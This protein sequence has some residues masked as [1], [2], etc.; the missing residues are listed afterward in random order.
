MNCDINSVIHK[1]GEIIAKYPEISDK[2]IQKIA[3]EVRTAVIQGNYSYTDAQKIQIQNAFRDNIKTLCDF[4]GYAEPQNIQLSFDKPEKKSESYI[5]EDNTTSILEK[6][7]EQKLQFNRNFLE[8]FESSPETYT[9]ITH[10]INKLMC[11]A[12]L[13]N[14]LSG[15]TINQENLSLSI[16]ISQDDLLRSIVDYLN[17]DCPSKNSYTE[18]QKK[19][20]ED[21]KDTNMFD[22][23]DNYTGVVGKLKEGFI[24]ELSP[25]SG[26]NLVKLQQNANNGDAAA[27]ARIQAI[28]NYA[29]LTN[30]PKLVKSTFGDA[31]Y[32]ND[33]LPKYNYYK[34]SV[35]DKGTSV[36]K[37]WRSSD[38]IWL[39]QEINRVVQ[40]IITS[41]DIYDM[42]S[43]ISSSENQMQFNIFYQTISKIKNFANSGN[44]WD[45]EKFKNAIQTLKDSGSL[46]EYE[47]NFLNKFMNKGDA[48]FGKLVSIANLNPQMYFKLIFELLGNQTCFK[49]IMAGN[50]K[51]FNKL[52][53]SYIYSTY[54]NF[55]AS[56]SSLYQASKDNINYYSF[57]TQVMETIN[58]IN[59]N[60]FYKNDQG[61]VD[62]RELTSSQLDTINRK[63]SNSIN[64]RNF[65]ELIDFKQ[66]FQKPYDIKYITSKGTSIEWPYS[67]S[68]KINDPDGTV[69]EIYVGKNN[70]N[71]QDTVAKNELIYS[72]KTYKKEGN[73]IVIDKEAKTQNFAVNW[74]NI[75]KFAPFIKDVLG[76]D[77]SVQSTIDGLKMATG[78]AQQQSELPKYLFKLAS[79]ALFRLSINN[80][81]Q[82]DKKPFLSKELGRQGTLNRLALIY[83]EKINTEANVIY[84][85]INDSWINIISNSESDKDTME[86]ISTYFAFNQGLLSSSV[87]KDGNGNALSKESLSSLDAS[88]RT[89]WVTLNNAEDSASRGFSILRPGVLQTV[90]NMREF[91]DAYGQQKDF[92]QFTP[93]EM[94]NGLFLYNFLNT[95]TETGDE[96]K[97]NIIRIL[98]AV[99][100]DKPRTDGLNINLNQDSGLGG[101]NGQIV[102]FKQAFRDPN[103]RL[104]SAKIMK[105]ELGTFYNESIKNIEH[106]YST[107]V[108]DLLSTHPELGDL[109]IE[110][111]QTFFDAINKIAASKNMNPLDYLNSLIIEYNNKNRNN[112]ITFTDQIHYIEGKN[113][114][115]VNQ[116]LIALR[117]RFNNTDRIQSYMLESEAQL[118]S[119][120][121][122]DNTKIKTINQIGKSILPNVEDEWKDP[123]GYLILGKITYNGVEYNISSRTDLQKFMR[124]NMSGFNVEDFYD[125]DK[126]RNNFGSRLQIKL[127]PYIAKYN[128]INYLFGQEWINST[129]GMHAT[130]PSKAKFE[131]INDL[132]KR[133]Q[134]ELVDSIP[135]GKLTSVDK[136]GKI[137][138]IKSLEKQDIINYL[139]GKVNDPN[140]GIRLRSIQSSDDAKLFIYYYD[141]RILETIGNVNYTDAANYAFNQL[142]LSKKSFLIEDE[143]S[144]WNAQVKRNV[145]F[146]ATM[147]LF[148]LGQIDGISE[149]SNIAIIEEDFDTLSNIL[150]QIDSSVSPFDGATFV[151]PFT[152]RLENNS[153]NGSKVGINKKIFI[154][155][156]NAQNGTGGIIKTAGFGLTNARIVRSEYFKTMMRNMTDRVWLNEDG[157]PAIINLL[158]VDY[159]G[160]EIEK[161]PQATYKGAD[162]NY[163]NVEITKSLGNNQYEI[164]SIQVDENNIP[165]SG[166]SDTSTVTINS[167]YTLWKA[168]GGEFSKQFNG[169]EFELSED[170]INITTDLI[171]RIGYPKDKYKSI[172]EWQS[173]LVRDHSLE[174]EVYTQDAIYQPMKQGDIH[175]MPVMSSVKQGAGNINR[176]STYYRDEDYDKGIYGDPTHINFMKVKMLQS[177]I[178]LDKEHGAD[179]EEVSLMTQVISACAARGFTR[180][181]AQRLYDGMS[182]LVE[183]NIKD[184]IDALHEYIDAPD[185]NPDKFHELILRTVLDSIAHQKSDPSSLIQQV[186][187][188]IVGKL[189]EGK[190]L[191]YKEMSGKIPYSDDGIIKQINSILS[192]ALTK[193]D[194]KLKLPGVLSV[195]CPSYNIMKLYGNRFLD[196]YNGKE[197]IL[198]RQKED[199]DTHPLFVYSARNSIVNKL[200][201]VNDLIEQAENDTNIILF[202]GKDIGPDEFKT[203]STANKKLLLAN[204]EAQLTLS[205]LVTLYISGLGKDNKINLDSFKAE[206]GIQNLKAEGKSY[207][208]SKNSTLTVDGLIERII[209]DLSAKN[210]LNIQEYDSQTIKNL[211][212]DILRNYNKDSLNEVFDQLLDTGNDEELDNLNKKKQEY[213]EQLNATKENGV[214]ELYR[215]DQGRWYKITRPN[216]AVE[217]VFIDT[218]YYD[219]DGKRGRASIIEEAKAGKIIS[220]VE[221]ITKGRNLSSYDIEFEDTQGIKYGL[222]DLTPAKVLFKLNYFGTDKVGFLE[223]ASKQFSTLLL[224]PDI[225]KLSE[226]D[227]QIYQLLSEIEKES[228]DGRFNSDIV[229]DRID[230]TITN[231]EVLNFINIQARR[232]LQ[233]NLSAIKSNGSI[234]I[235][236]N[237]VT[238][239]G[240][241]SERAAEVILPKTAKA[242]FGLSNNDSLYSILS[243]N[244][245][246]A[247]KLLKHLKDTINVEHDIALRNKKGDHE[248]I[249]SKDSFDPTGYTEEDIYSSPKDKNGII[250]RLDSDGKKIY[251]ISSPNDK[252]YSKYDI[253]TGTKFEVIVTD[254]IPFYIKNHHYDLITINKNLDQEKLNNLANI[255]YEAGYKNSDNYNEAVET[256][257]KD[258]EESVDDKKQELTPEA[259]LQLFKERNELLQSN[260]L[261]LNDFSKGNPLLRFLMNYGNKQRV[262]FIK[263]LDTVA[264]RVPAQSMQSF[265]PMK[266]V[267]FDNQDKNTAYVSTSQIWLQGSDYD[268]DAVTITNFALN[269]NGIYQTWSPLAN[270]TKA[271]LLHASDK[272][273]LPTGKQINLSNIET[274]FSDISAEEFDLGDIDEL[275]GY[276][277]AKNKFFL[278]NNTNE[279]ILLLGQLIHYINVNTSDDES[280]YNIFY[281]GKDNNKQ[282]LQFLLEKINAHNKYLNTL[283][284]KTRENAIINFMTTNMFDIASN[285]VNLIEASTPIDRA[286]KPLKTVANNQTALKQEQKQA[287]IGNFMITLHSIRENQVGKSG[288]GICAVGL[289]SFFAYTQVANNIIAHGN[290]D[291]KKQATFNIV[292]N[293]K[294]Y[295]TLANAFT[296]GY[297]TNLS[298][299]E[300][301]QKSNIIRD[302]N[303]AEKLQA[304][305][306]LLANTNQDVD[307]AVTLSA[308]LSLATDNAKE[309]ALAKL[310]AGTD[311]LG[312]YIFGISIGMPF[313]EISNILTNPKIIKLGQLAISNIF[314]DNDNALNLDRV[315]QYI[316]EGPIID[317]IGYLENFYKQITD[318]SQAYL[319]YKQKRLQANKDKPQHEDYFADQLKAGLALGKISIEDLESVRRKLLQEDP[320]AD[321][322]HYTKLQ[323]LQ[324]C[325]DYIFNTEGM[326]DR[327]NNLNPVVKDFITLHRG[328]NELRV[329]GQVLHINQGLYTSEFEDLNYLKQIQ[330]LIADRYID[331]DEFKQQRNASKKNK[332]TKEQVYKQLKIDVHKFLYDDEYKEKIIKLYDNYKIAFNIPLL[333]ANSSQYFSY[334]K[335]AD[336]LDQQM[337]LISAKHRG[338]KK[339]QPTNTSSKA[340]ETL[341]NKRINILQNHYMIDKFLLSSRQTFILP[342]GDFL[343]G[344]SANVSNRGAYTE[345]Q[346]MKVEENTQV[347]LG[348][349]QGNATF[350]HW[351]ENTV[352]PALQKDPKYKDNEFI[353]SLI[354]TIMIDNPTYNKSIVYSANANMLPRSEEETIA[355]KKLQQEFLKLFPR[356]DSD[357]GYYVDKAGN[358]M[359]IRDLLFMYQ[360]IVMHNSPGE[361]KLK[362]IFSQSFDDGVIKDFYSFVSDFDV[363]DEIV[364][365][366][367]TLGKYTTLKE[368]PRSTYGGE[369]YYSLN[370]DFNMYRYYVDFQSAQDYGDYGEGTSIIKNKLGNPMSHSKLNFDN[371]HVYFDYSGNDIET[372]INL[373]DPITI[374]STTIP[375]GACRIKIHT[376]GVIPSII[377]IS[378]Q[379]KYQE[380]IEFEESQDSG[381]RNRT[382]KNAS[383]DATIALAVDFNNTGEILT[384][385]SVTDQGKKYIDVNVNDSLEVTQELVNRIVD[386]LNE[387]GAKTLNIAGNGIYTMKGKYTQ[388]QID[389]FTYDLLNN[390]INS[391][392]LENTIDSIRSGGQTGFD[393]AGIKAALRLGIHA[394]VLAP[395][396]WKFRNI[397]GTDISD[398]EDFKSRFIQGDSLYSVTW[399][400]SSDNGFEVSTS[401]GKNKPGDS[402]FS[403]KKAVFKSGTIIQ[404]EDV[405]GETIETVYQSLIKQGKLTRGDD[406]KTGV[407][408][409]LMFHDK[410]MYKQTMSKE[411]REDF[412][413]EVGYLPLWKEWA[414]QNPDLIEELRVES[415]GKVLT[416]Q[417]ATKTR[418]SQA[419]ALADILNSDQTTKTKVGPTVNINFNTKTV[420]ISDGDHE[421]KIELNPKD[422]IYLTFMNTKGDTKPKINVNKLFSQ[423]DNII[424]KC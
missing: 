57:L 77:L 271:S 269:R 373:S 194:I 178:Q 229:K 112:P 245:F 169:E 137:S 228:I 52:D 424:N 416:D 419:R 384:K 83:G 35:A 79:R 166:K 348:T 285:P 302:G 193:D 65:K 81:I 15:I 294:A 396:G 298:L 191:T 314:I 51:V 398:E 411:E 295:T 240:I 420:T 3:D 82:S 110:Y 103:W 353:K 375:A 60:Q 61:N 281:S 389:E 325:E 152:V 90:T 382:I 213:E 93:A 185:G 304:A 360:L 95:F 215:I 224:K 63:I 20:L 422:M 260:T 23:Y 288:V 280:T 159:K 31:I 28:I 316:K 401:A 406:H 7:V 106:S 170:S 278:K 410:D 218:P 17:Y 400:T 14:K 39:D 42:G 266:I 390:V 47:T 372:T 268:I 86:I 165:V 227:K 127:N 319:Q 21:I 174:G 386:E 89:Q 168:L 5:T 290:L 297:T 327:G 121:M 346:L 181:Y 359:A 226:R 44:A 146:S 332:I 188:Q 301:K 207:L 92:M 150:G 418:V 120:L 276:N 179:A 387:S 311:M 219:I 48:S 196:E 74:N 134:I 101:V 326:S 251:P 238:V 423:I 114:L 175:Y 145:S 340:K 102:T 76:I 158:G 249:I 122:K 46:S 6:P 55:F 275:V 119:Y 318:S 331:S 385:K 403:A 177:G 339:Y 299:E 183:T 136:N 40:S 317:R 138:I 200:K 334:L 222:Y 126:I 347:R 64:N 53:K 394:T 195:L 69:Y 160:Q 9:K 283:D 370:G 133:G 330:N 414:R 250:W 364:L 287:R 50:E 392:R 336:L 78:N 369:T 211:V 190:E 107:L 70:S 18:S 212:V 405:G 365:D 220:I 180:E 203:L 139:S 293:G 43:S 252:V 397:N 408:R 104:N 305:K 94:F 96:L 85:P 109:K 204:H 117:E 279:K 67:I 366:P 247:R 345:P 182:S 135:S 255:V 333:I 125:S 37:T 256:Q 368:N 232:E 13:Y 124:A 328:A 198:K 272:L 404:G 16:A 11:N 56:E 273:D 383:A 274:R 129:V 98:G 244:N 100:S 300:V 344:T 376:N 26:S 323:I 231:D 291:Q 225:N 24:S 205:G 356:A 254:N 243:D 361:Y 315:E 172:Q 209:T 415:D 241:I 270:I 264:A 237:R 262:S 246:F 214:N 113:G 49:Y 258:I 162:G 381:Y 343:Y 208:V 130:H 234:N 367:Y 233:E 306:D 202:N 303:D 236:G 163:Y 307:A 230:S 157:T 362:T 342:K 12:F 111:D 267:G 320:E 210:E 322:N 282:K 75:S 350:K 391:P 286:T 156:Y 184:S 399:A 296:P 371:D 335:L 248:Y 59:Y 216:G 144:R 277:K 38:Q 143:A 186:T 141:K 378:T 131:Y 206:T 27:K 357:F 84:N 25:L 374:G 155:Y 324:N 289:K 153:L 97:S 201:E 80:Y 1:V 263:V 239:A 105:Q 29:M 62:V 221:D 351:M 363:N 189:K 147:H 393:E 73:A 4:F 91:V 223:E 115:Q 313:T 352:I 312:I 292:I 108:L 140:L 308:L 154:H 118:F 32:V 310:N 71:V 161:L 358:K 309:L 217:S 68:F 187:K 149:D 128:H 87:T 72:I 123:S 407:P 349:Y 148:Q 41:A 176:A 337:T 54:K 19:I 171:N 173:S 58:G 379:Q 164:K 341:I 261:K 36:W 99:I 30:F 354:S 355:F 116:T 10:Q 199:Y 421:Y 412:S 235:D 8:D 417:H 2:N 197:D 88:Y 329:L 151:N 402:R 253:A 33:S 321:K 377:D 22:D 284:S 265:M 257:I 380:N 142:N 395:K 192:V 242:A 45:V 338:L 388:A 409:P 167:N 34:Y 66:T 413:Y 132:Q 259:K